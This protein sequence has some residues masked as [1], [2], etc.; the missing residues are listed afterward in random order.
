MIFDKFRLDGRVAL[1]TGAG[2]GLG[3]AM[4]VALAEA[5]ADVV[6][7]ARTVQQIE[8]TA[9]EV[10]QTG[11]NCLPVRAD[12]SKSVEVRALVESTLARF[13]KIDILVNNAGG[14]TPRS[15]VAISDEEWKE[16]LDANLSSVFYCCREVGR[17][18]I[19]RGK[20]KIIN[21]SSTAGVVASPKNAPYHV[22]KAGIIL[23][24]RALAVEWAR[25]HINV[26]AIG[27][28]QFRTSLTEGY[29]S[30]DLTREAVL[31]RIPQRR[32]GLPEELGP[33]A[34]YLASDASDFM[35]GEVIFIDGGEL[36][37]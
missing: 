8:Q 29:L 32:V 4:A 21:I 22:A 11:R 3:K 34:V 6:V 23:L 17:Q 35:T 26:N 7:A 28:G 9:S 13:G 30:N 36:V 27:P 10:R 5:G 31:S 33:L 20:G 16:S 14:G 24:T 15:F 25:Y 2:R 12:V 1:V 19:A 37:V 18:M